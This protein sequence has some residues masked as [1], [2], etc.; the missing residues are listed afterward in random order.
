MLAM[1]RDEREE[2]KER[3]FVAELGALFFVGERYTE[4]RLVDDAAR[5]GS[6]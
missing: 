3:F 6:L 4:E 2:Q 5:P 1:Q